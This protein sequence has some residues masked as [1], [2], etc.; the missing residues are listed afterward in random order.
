[1][2]V[3]SLTLFPA[4]SDFYSEV[5]RGGCK[6]FTLCLIHVSLMLH[7]FLRRLLMAWYISE[8]EYKICKYEWY[9]TQSDFITYE[10]TMC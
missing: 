1:M 6:N 4:N 9:F 10:P 3:I 7:Y 8:L 5:D 2:Y